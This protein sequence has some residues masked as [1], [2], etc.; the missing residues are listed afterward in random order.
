MSPDVFTSEGGGG[1]RYFRL[2]ASG[3]LISVFTNKKA[4]IRPSISLKNGITIVDND[5]DG[6]VNKPYVIK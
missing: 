2:A 4:A 3:S 6:T 5:A 1:A